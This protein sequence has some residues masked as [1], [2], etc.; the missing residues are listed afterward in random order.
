MTTESCKSKPY[1]VIRPTTRRPG[2]RDVQT[3]L[4]LGNKMSADR[5]GVNV[6]GG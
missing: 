3:G 1:I 6:V 4:A 2:K 5:E